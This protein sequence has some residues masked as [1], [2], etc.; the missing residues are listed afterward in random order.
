[1]GEFDIVHSHSHFYFSTNLASLISKITDTNL[2]ITN[3]GF[4][5]QTAPSSIENVYNNT[6]GKL[7][8]N[9]AVRVFCYTPRAKNILREHNITSP[10]EIISNGVNCKV[11][12][13]KDEKDKNRQILFVGRLKNGKR[14]D[15]LIRGF[16]KI[17]DEYP[18]Y[19]L[20]IV[21]DGPMF[22]DLKALCDEQNIQDKVTF[23]GELPYDEMPDVYRQSDLL[24]LPTETEAAIPRVVMEAWACETPAIMPNIQE[25]DSE[26][27]KKGGLLCDGSP[28]EIYDAVCQLIEDD[29]LCSTL[30]SAGRGI[31]QEKYSWEDTVKKTTETYY[32]VING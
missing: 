8:L 32:E 18:N 15:A 3:H 30:G 21:G 2:V 19:Q 16:G 20:K 26:T 31:V 22:S 13:S 10:I 7:T 5:S 4:F 9:S 14:P 25:I 28:D 23:T 17:A 6:I 1:V 12:T 24:V 29:Q 27:F 11:F